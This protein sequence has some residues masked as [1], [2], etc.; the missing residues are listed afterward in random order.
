MTRNR[1]PER[2]DPLTSFSNTLNRM[3]RGSNKSIYFKQHSSF[4]T[5]ALFGYGE[6]FL[7]R[8]ASKESSLL[9]QRHVLQ[10]FSLSFLLGSLCAPGDLQISFEITGPNGRFLK[11]PKEAYAIHCCF[12]SFIM[13]YIK[14]SVS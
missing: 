7:P 11:L 2:K 6:P 9:P 13:Q 1:V 4:Q 14:S 12:I 5:P 8:Q 10:G 3:C